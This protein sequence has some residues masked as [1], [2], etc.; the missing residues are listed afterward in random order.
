MMADIYLAID[1]GGTNIKYGLIDRGGK[2]VEKHTVPTPQD[3]F[4]KFVGALNQLIAQY[5]ER[6]KGVAL[7]VPGTVVHPQELILG[8][9][10]VPFLDHKEL[11]KYLKVPAG[12]PLAVENDGKSAAL[13]EMWLGNLNGVVNG[14]AIVLGTAIGGGLIINQHLYAGS[15]FQAGEFSFMSNSHDFSEKNIIGF[16]LG[17]AVGMIEHVSEALNLP[18][19]KD[20]R[21]VFAEINQGNPIALKIFHE[22]CREI[23]LLIINVQSVVDMERFVIGGGIS[24]QPIVISSIDAAYEEA[25][26]QIPLLDKTFHR[27][28]IV[29]GKFQNDANMYGAL[30]NLLLEVNGEDDETQWGV[31]HQ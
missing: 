26:Q 9:G 1:V 25:R 14:A 7:S 13:A 28:E 24:A 18:T 17:S 29:A 20:G 12:V 3:S 2:L 19:K 5:G 10:N 8:G 31:Q 30:Y 11:P 23:A 21:A 6:L 15:H 22:F 16:N 27:P 4:D